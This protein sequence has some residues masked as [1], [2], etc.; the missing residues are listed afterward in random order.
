MIKNLRNFIRDKSLIKNVGYRNVSGIFALGADSLT[1]EKMPMIP[2]PKSAVEIYNIGSA[3]RKVPMAETVLRKKSISVI[4]FLLCF[5]SFIAIQL[6]TAAESYAQ[7]TTD[8][9]Q[10]D[11]GIYHSA[12]VRNDG[13]LWMTGMNRDGRLGDG[14]QENKTIP[15]KVMDDVKEVCCGL[16]HTVILKDDGSLWTVGSNHY[17]QLGDGTNE[18]KTSP[19]RV[20]TGVAQISCGY[21]FTAILKEDG[22]LYMTGENRSGQ[23]GDGTNNNRSY[24]FKVMD[25]VAQVS[26]GASHCAILKKDGHLYTTGSNYEGQ[27]G[28]GEWGEYHRSTPKD[29]MSNVSQVCCGASHTAAIQKDG[30]LYMTGQNEYGQLGDGN[31]NGGNSPAFVLVM[32]NVAQISCGVRH[33][34]IITKDGKLLMTGNNING[35]FGNDS[36][37]S[38]CTPIPVMDDVKQVSCGN[39]HSG[40]I[41]KDGSLWTTGG[42][43]DGQ[44]GVKTSS[45][46]IFSPK[47]V[48]LGFTLGV[49]NNSWDH[50]YREGAGFEGI[51][52]YSFK[53]EDGKK[54]FGKLI[55]NATPGETLD[56]IR[57]MAESVTTQNWKGS[58]YGLV[59]TIG[60]SYREYIDL[61][62]ITANPKNC[63]SY[64]SLK[65]PCEDDRL[66]NA[67]HYYYFSQWVSAASNKKD[68]TVYNKNE[69]N[70]LDRMY[71]NTD[72]KAFFEE[73]IERA[74]KEGTV[75]LGVHFPEGGHALLATGHR[76]DEK[77]NKHILDIYDVNDPNKSNFYEWTIDSDLKGF[78]LDF[79]HGP[80]TED[81][82]KVLFFADWDSMLDLNGNAFR[83]SLQGGKITIDGNADVRITA[84][85]GKY[86]QCKAGTLSGDMNIY[87]MSPMISGDG[88][89]YTIYT[90][91]I[92]QY[93]ITDMT[94]EVNLSVSSSKGYAA[95]KGTDIQYADMKP[96]E[97]TMLIGDDFH[98]NLYSSTNS[99]VGENEPGMVSFEGNCRG[100]VSVYAEGD[101]A[102]MDTGNV[103]YI[104]TDLKT[105]Q[106]VGVNRATKEYDGII[107][108]IKVPAHTH[109][110]GNWKTSKK[111]TE[112]AAG[113]KTRTCP[114]CGS[115]ETKVIPQL[116]P[117]LKAVKIRKPKA[118]KKAAVI[119]WNKIAKRNKTKKVEIQYSTDRNFKKGVKTKYASA[120]KTSFQIKNLKK[121][122]KYYVR[123]RAYTKAGNKVHVSKWSDTKTVRAK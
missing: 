46:K 90:D 17:G 89:S 118:Q 24:P 33:S 23:L 98:F 76:Y 82:F 93:E 18:T 80:I 29:V 100:A 20:M 35:E 15:V 34:G 44:L 10:V 77:N 22:R 91:D 122:R 51:G 7:N 39:W 92:D 30:S 121:D 5:V 116:K 108:S 40:I 13:S 66:L 3:E 73:L 87:H 62:D 81:N 60:L 48:L 75:F 85:D 41:K 61:K 106:Y 67:I 95:L 28:D 25:D 38:V 43:S 94:G 113:A 103:D 52:D 70:L 84:K 104:V 31:D 123:I 115:T 56:L 63:S 11:C 79:S 50:H 109:D 110:Y 78:S 6:I 2:V 55:K 49:H 117:T 102:R 53:G 101:S 21:D 64:Y 72:L 74:D 57:R 112:I 12:M 96:G 86:I 105:T 32:D 42:N 65:R 83:D 111:A 59:S 119:K 114:I 8:V 26:C 54:Q 45:E 27:L 9:M 58:C 1:W 14:T 71:V 68:H 36:D 19:V 69:F 97:E 16:E 47:R 4:C 107:Q 99:M 120:K 88:I 37:Q